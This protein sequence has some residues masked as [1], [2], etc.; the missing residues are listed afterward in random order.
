MNGPGSAFGLVHEARSPA[1][2]KTMSDNTISFRLRVDHFA[3]GS[4]G[5]FHAQDDMGYSEASIVMETRRGNTTYEREVVMAT[6]I[7]NWWNREASDTDN[8]IAAQDKAQAW[9]EE[10]MRKMF[11]SF[12]EYNSVD[13]ATTKWRDR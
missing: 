3:I 13:Y 9:M 5:R 12:F 1:H 7:F 6:T 8:E 11:G 2:T 4:Y 10:G